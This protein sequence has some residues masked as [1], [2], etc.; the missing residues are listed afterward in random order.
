MI[1][2]TYATGVTFDAE[3]TNG[4]KPCIGCVCPRCLCVCER[5]GS[6]APF[7]ASNVLINFDPVI[8]NAMQRHIP[9]F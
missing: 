7:E 2:N 3:C 4:G 5:G 9:A 1:L 6:W 8:P